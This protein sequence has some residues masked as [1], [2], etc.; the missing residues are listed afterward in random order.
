MTPDLEVHDIVG[1]LESQA[2]IPGYVQTNGSL[3]SQ[4]SPELAATVSQEDLVVLEGE[5]TVA[6]T[7]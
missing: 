7:H 5:G 2:V 3:D 1:V 6:T 4:E